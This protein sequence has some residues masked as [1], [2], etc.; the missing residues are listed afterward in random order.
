[1]KNTVYKC[2]YCGEPISVSAARRTQRCRICARKAVSKNAEAKWQKHNEEHPHYCVVC[3]NVIKWDIYKEAQNV[4]TCSRHC[5]GLLVQSKL[6]ESVEHLEMRLVAYIKDQGRYV[7]LKELREVFKISDKLLYS[8][9]MSCAALNRKAGNYFP[10]NKKSFDQV[11]TEYRQ[12]LKDNPGIRVQEA[13]RAI[14]VSMKYITALGIKPGDLRK[15]LGIHNKL[16]RTKE[17]IEA[18]ILDW[19]SK[20]PVYVPAREI[21]RAL[22]IDF[23]CS[24]QKKG[25]DIEAL[26]IAAGHQPVYTS[27]YESYATNSFTGASLRFESQKTFDDLKAKSKLRFDFWF[28]D[29]NLLLEIDGQQHEKPTF[30]KEALA[31]TKSHDQL[32]ENYAKE[33]GLLLV[34]IKA[35]PRDTFIERI[36]DFIDQIKGMPRVSGVMHTDSNC[37]KLPPDNTEDNPQP[38]PVMGRFN[39]YPAKEYSQAAGSG[40]GLDKEFEI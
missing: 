23:A 14:G 24:I 34:R 30:G 33:H 19:L 9:H 38:S 32:K 29:Y 10:E 4:K 17:Q 35:T 15:E 6:K 26:N 2:K 25:I 3:G 18:E 27:Y 39:D 36:N 13:A 1:M 5:A 8:R 16:S 31:M 11:K 40:S 12:L 28:P 7:S 22:H 21:C 20:Q 37:G